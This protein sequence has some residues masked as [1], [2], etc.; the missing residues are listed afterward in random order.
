MANT[1]VIGLELQDNGSIKSKTRDTKE[2]NQQLVNTSK[3]SKAAFAKTSSQTYDQARAG[4]GTGAAG[5]DFAKESQG[6]GGLVRVYATFAANVF[7]VSA[8]FSALKNAAD[9]TSLVQG[10]DQIGAASGRNLGTLA[11]QMVAATDGALSLRDAMASTAI[12]SSGGM[13]N[14]AI[15]RMTEV[16]K[17]ASI[18]LGRDMS[19]SM[20]RLTK[21]II[22]IQPELLDELG[23]MTRVIP[24]QQEYARQLGKSVSALTD[25]EKRQAFANAVLSEGEKKFNA[26][27][28][29]ANPYS[30]LLATI[31]D[32][33][34]SALELINKG[35]GP[36]A[37]LLG[38]NPTALMGVLGLITVGLLKQAIPAIGG[39]QK[40]IQEAT[41]EARAHAQEVSDVYDHYKTGI[42]EKD[43]SKQAVAYKTASV[44]AKGHADSLIKL[45]GINLRTKVGKGIVALAE[46]PGS[47]AKAAAVEAERIKRIKVLQSEATKSISAEKAVAN[48]KELTGL[49]NLQQ[50]I[51]KTITLQK[52]LNQAGKEYSPVSGGMVSVE[53]KQR[54]NLASAKSKE[55]SADII[56]GI[57]ERVGDLG[58]M[59]AVG[60]TVGKISKNVKTLGTVGTVFTAI[61]A[62]AVLAYEG[63]SLLASGL[64]SVFF[65]VTTV[66]TV[67]SFLNEWFTSNAKE[68]S[69]FSSSID[70]LNSSFANVDRT[71]DVIKNKTPLERLSI[72]SIGA[73]AGAFDDLTGSLDKTFKSFEKFKT[74]PTNIWDKA[75]E[76]IFSFFGS[77]SVDTLSEGLSKSIE[78][79][80]KLLKTS[81][82][83]KKFK[84]SISKILKI[85]KFDT[86]SITEALKKLDTAE[87]VKAVKELGDVQSKTNVEL[88]N[89]ASRLQSYKEAIDNTT[90]AHQ[91]LLNSYNLTDP[92][93]KFG[94]SLITTANSM[95]GLL[96]STTES[97]AALLDLFNSTEKMSALGG[98]FANKLASIKDEYLASI[99][100]IKNYADEVDNAREAYEKLK[101][102]NNVNPNLTS[103]QLAQIT[104]NQQGMGSLLNRAAQQ[105]VED[106][107]TN[108]RELQRF[109]SQNDLR[110]Q[111]QKTITIE[112]QKI[113]AEGMQQS[114]IKGSA[115]IEQAL[116]SASAKAAVTIARGALG[117]LTGTA[118][119][120]AETKLSNMEAGIQKTAIEVVKQ[121]IVETK[122]LNSNL[123]RANLLAEEKRETSKFLP[124]E[125][126]LKQIRESLTVNTIENAGLTGSSKALRA[127][128]K[129]GKTADPESALAKAAISLSPTDVQLQQSDAQK[130]QI[131]AQQESIKLAN[132][133]RNA[134]AKLA[135]TTIADL[136]FTKSRLAIDHERLN[137]TKE[138]VGYD[139][140]SMV[141]SRNVLDMDILKNNLLEEQETLKAKIKA[142]DDTANAP[143][144][145]PLTPMLQ[146]DKLLLKKQLTKAESLQIDKEANQQ[147]KNNINYMKSAQLYREKQL[148]VTLAIRNSNMKVLESELSISEAQ[149]NK[150]NSL[151]LIS[152]SQKEDASTGIAA[153]KLRVESQNKELEIT[154][155]RNQILSDYN[156]KVA[157]LGDKEYQAAAEL[158]VE[159]E[160][161]LGLNK[162]SAA[163]NKNDLISK[164]EL[165]AINKKINN[166]EEI[167]LSRQIELKQSSRALTN[168]IKFA[169]LDVA[170][171][172]NTKAL[173]MGMITQD[174]KNQRDYV[175]ATV[176]IDREN[177]AQIA[178]EKEKLQ[179]SDLAYN[180][181]LDQLAGE[182]S[183]ELDVT[184]VKEQLLINDRITALGVEG[185]ARL[186]ILEIN[187]Q[188]GLQE[189]AINDFVIKGI[190]GMSDA[191]VDFA[192]TGKQS[193]GDMVQSM[194]MDLAKLEMRMMF[195]RGLKEAGGT[196]GII[197]SIAKLF[198]GGGASAGAPTAFDAMIAFKAKGAAYD[199]G[200]QAFA[201][202]GTFTNSIVSSPTLFKFAKGTG[203]MGEAGPEAIMPLKRGADG[204]L[205]VEGGSGGQ[206]S[207]V[208]N[209]YSTAQAET[210]ESVDSRGNRKI[211]VTIGDMTAGEMARSGSASQKTMRST[212]GMAPQLIRR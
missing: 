155:K 125:A 180:R 202:G 75:K 156:A 118:A 31:K 86:D 137:I 142:L 96:G 104:A 160:R 5:R 178:A 22:K 199:S 184:Y 187:K 46:D 87:Q 200:V 7:A 134:L 59:N 207:V 6:L 33:A 10:L 143:G 211:E 18:A 112:A 166:D 14:S 11:K 89:G 119:I 203:L 146:A 161:L 80:I 29:D 212:F 4:G 58:Y 23:I 43:V 38:E 101:A 60:D 130:R 116:G 40:G 201:K 145:A 79:S 24:S 152:D 19:D 193:F 106:A 109:Q 17:K 148:E 35:L 208:V 12:A 32:V 135:E 50:E 13:T 27:N 66:V 28:I 81:G 93:S 138:I 188:L 183:T 49:N 153:N 114:F 204:S 57:S 68:S 82:D 3:A 47:A 126:K 62:G 154:D 73:V 103:Q 185:S 70:T 15:L 8:A 131:D 9:T 176:K 37:K 115:L 191:F 173:S 97:Q 122:L 51:I 94:S 102:S 111:K 92:L 21:G 1:V 91:D 84:N 149:V 186:K 128:V 26:I 67:L 194:I 162:I 174:E 159:K 113:L 133:Y 52:Q 206:T 78:S 141:Q 136:N 124:D 99:G 132:I 169:E 117:G 44:A 98:D 123:E 20:E 71:I 107:S 129:A 205:G 179:Q 74:V 181:K 65:I 189:Q 25:F 55:A 105:P 88:N 56:G 36:I 85:D 69:N 77:G 150:A 147:L 110:L 63:V 45:E 151:G 2:L 34:F 182:S 95:Q 190:E 192:F 54:R 158:S 127:I 163:D 61:K 64:S 48:Q 177:Q 171:A 167:A 157:L 172:K 108:L 30:K 121:Q 39:W 165:L 16:A 144:A 76:G 164:L 140:Y 120:D 42:I 139:S 83:E 168:A 209:N 100:S 170:D 210:K 196:S 53:A 195:M 175:N 41:K 198:T 90:K 72:T 197:G